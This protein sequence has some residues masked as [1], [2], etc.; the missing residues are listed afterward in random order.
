MTQKDFDNI[1]E[2]Y[3]KVYILADESTHKLLSTMKND[4]VELIKAVENNQQL[5]PILA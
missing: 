3:E 1:K 4:I 5:E 2:R